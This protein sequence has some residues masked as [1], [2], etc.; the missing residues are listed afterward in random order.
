MKR[1]AVH[2]AVLAL[3]FARVAN[4]DPVAHGGSDADVLFAEAKAL[5]EAGHYSE[6][7]AKFAESD[8]RAPGIGVALYLG[9]CYAHVGR[10]TRAWVAF[11][12][13]EKRAREKHDDRVQIAEARVRALEPK[14]GRVTFSVAKSLRRSGVEIWLDGAGPVPVES[15]EGGVVAEPGDHLVELKFAGRSVRTTTAHVT[16]EGAVA[17]VTLEEPPLPP[18]PPSAPPAARPASV[19]TADPSSSR[20]AIGFC[21][22]GVGV[23][24]IGTGAAFLIAKNASSSDGAPNGSPSVNQGQAAASGVAFAVGGAAL[25][26]AVVLYLTTPKRSTGALTLSPVPLV[27]GGGAFLQGIF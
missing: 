8:R 20:A 2:G 12:S 6:A 13:A 22:L 9:D 7:C 27:G 5:R 24:S 16:A 1:A 11:K 17:P 26:S 10:T 19:S 15:Y 25:A 3:A 4:A 18:L 23:V 21:L 14:L